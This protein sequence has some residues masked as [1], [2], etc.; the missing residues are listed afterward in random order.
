M[1]VSNRLLNLAK[2]P[3]VG[4][5]LREHMGNIPPK[6]RTRKDGTV[7]VTKHG[8]TSHAAVVAVHLHLCDEC[9][10][11][12][13]YANDTVDQV[14]EATGLG[15]STVE[16]ALAVLDHP[17]WWPV[18]PGGR[19]RGGAAGVA[20]EGSHRVPAWATWAD[21]GRGTRGEGDHDPG[22][23]TRGGGDATLTAVNDD[24]HRVNDDPHRVNDR[25]SPR[26]TRDST[27]TDVTTKALSPRDERE[28]DGKRDRALW[29]VAND[30]AL[31]HTAHR[32]SLGEPFDSQRAYAASFTDEVVDFIRDRL[33]EGDGPDAIALALEDQWPTGAATAAT[34]AT[35]AYLRD[36]TYPD[37][38]T[39]GATAP[40]R[41][42]EL[43]CGCV[44][45]DGRHVR[46][47]ATHP[48]AD[49]LDAPTYDAAAMAIEDA[50]RGL[51]VDRRLD[52]EL[53]KLDP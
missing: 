10:P 21:P 13:G 31:D 17:D 27:T 46:G 37:R 47:C 5:R 9:R 18:P 15:A 35:V 12:R 53:G 16:R 8:G 24:P 4:Q 48:L 40:S 23:G 6:R 41:P 7:A 43:D 45:L 20:G 22:R 50:T 19:G 34:T 26:H 11:G 1:A 32:A 33:A 51:V 49:E 3:I 25:P 2:R 36:G 42:V 28:R 14:A 44:H 29:K 38:P 39:N 30:H 52:D